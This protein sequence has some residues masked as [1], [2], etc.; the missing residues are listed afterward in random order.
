MG[1]IIDLLTGT[2]K[3]RDAW[4]KINTNFTRVKTEVDAIVLGSANAEVGQ[5][6][7]STAK[8]KTFAVIDDRFEE[9]ETDLADN[10]QHMSLG[11][12]DKDIYPEILDMHYDTLKGI[13]WNSLESG[14][15][16]IKSITVIAIKGT[17]DLTLSSVTSLFTKQLIV[18]YTDGEYYPNVI[19]SIAVSYTHLTLPTTPYV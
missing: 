2:T 4:P 15:E 7:V 12:N 19:K 8:S 13:G 1:I 11:A 6:H 18:I 3:L 9:I 17:F 10:T 16:L 14:G 5:A